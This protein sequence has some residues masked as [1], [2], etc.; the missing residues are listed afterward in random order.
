MQVK[1]WDTTVLRECTVA[2]FENLKNPELFSDQPGLLAKSAPTAALRRSLERMLCLTDPLVAQ[3]AQ[4]CVCRAARA[5]VWDKCSVGDVV[6]YSEHG[7]TRCGLV[8]QHISATISDIE[9]VMSLVRP[10]IFQSEEV[11]RV[12]LHEP[13]AHA[14]WISTGSIVGQTIWTDAESA[15]V[16]VVRASHIE[17]RWA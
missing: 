12:S 14:Q 6:L 2:H 8:L 3:Q 4:I 10:L 9:C 11:E 5:S 7:L 16:R 17:P 13:A 1:A 15:P